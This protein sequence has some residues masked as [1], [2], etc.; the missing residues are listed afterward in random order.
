[1]YISK[2][3]IHS[4]IHFEDILWKKRNL[5]NCGSDL[6]LHFILSTSQ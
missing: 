4:F 5:K 6:K 2:I 1:M 3:N